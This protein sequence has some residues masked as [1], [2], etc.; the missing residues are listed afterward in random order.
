MIYRGNDSDDKGKHICFRTFGQS[1]RS[2]RKQMR[3]FLFQF[4]THLGRKLLFLARNPR[5]FMRFKS[6]QIA[7]RETNALFIRIL[8]YYSNTKIR[9]T[10]L[11]FSSPQRKQPRAKF[12]S[13]EERA[14]ITRRNVPF[15]VAPRFVWTGVPASSSVS[16]YF[17]ILKNISYVT[18]IEWNPEAQKA[19]SWL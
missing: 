3:M 6:V 11:F 9:P 19:S 4:M 7:R 17:R 5:T 18:R 12:N 1:C 13:F 15:P 10:I 14:S 8:S 16:A 2:F